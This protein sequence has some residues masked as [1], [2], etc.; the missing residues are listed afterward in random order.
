MITTISRQIGRR[1]P[2][3]RAAF[4]LVETLTTSG[5][6]GGGV[7]LDI[8]PTESRRLP[9]RPHSISLPTYVH[10]IYLPKRPHD[11]GQDDR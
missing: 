7:V 8:D 4:S 1:Y 10:N 3:M 5:T 11:V 9:S 6:V 2:Q